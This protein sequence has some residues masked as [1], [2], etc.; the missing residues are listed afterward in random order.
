MEVGD[1]IC[2]AYA[3]ARGFDIEGHF[4]EWRTTNPIDAE[5]LAMTNLYVDDAKT[6]KTCEIAC[7][8]E[9]CGDAFEAAQERQ[10]RAERRA[11]GREVA[12]VPGT[13]RPNPCLNPARGIWRDL[14]PN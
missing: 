2:D 5:V 13:T 12:L 4:A 6:S 1:F 3:W 10:E 7:Q 8:T 11:E 14:D 9:F